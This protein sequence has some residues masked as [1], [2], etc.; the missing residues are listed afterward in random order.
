MDDIGHNYLEVIKK[1]A[2]EILKQNLFSDTLA[3]IALEDISA[4]QHVVRTIL[5]R[6]DIEIKSVKSQY[7]L[8]NITSKDTI[9]DAYA[10]DS[11]GRQINIE[12]QRRDTV[13]HARRIRYYGSMIDKSILDK[14][15]YYD[16]LPDV[17]IIYISETDIWNAGK[18]V[19]PVK[20]ILGNTEIS[21]DDGNHVIFVNAA[22]DDGSDTAKLM[23]YFETADPDD[24]SQGALSER[25]HY[26]KCEKGGND[27]MC[28]AAENLYNQG[29]EQGQLENAKAMAISLHES[30]VSEDLIAKAANVSV[31]LVRKWL[32][33]AS[34]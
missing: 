9:L 32:G 7:R 21:Y 23:K 6:D 17:Y 15:A 8:L 31:E 16:E 30:G 12:I 14:G 20:K 34:A 5:G 24:M 11:A 4:C 13:D 33:L 1:G 2:E 26:L 3:S 25:I 19:Y 27:E 18:T 28:K 10:Q 22:I 29:K